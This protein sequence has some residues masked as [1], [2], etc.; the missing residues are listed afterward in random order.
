MQIPIVDRLA[1]LKLFLALF[2]LI[3]A[4]PMDGGRVLR[5]TL[6]S[7]IGFVRATE[8]A[9]SIG[10]FTA[11]ALGFIGLFP[12]SDPRLHNRLRLSGRGVRSAFGRFARRLAGRTGEPSDDESLRHAAA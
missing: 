6:A 4:F 11:F 9:A 1:A 3:P 5:A 10:Q 12:Q 2:N 8:R 7:R